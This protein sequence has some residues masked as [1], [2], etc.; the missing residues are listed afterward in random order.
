ME[1]AIRPFQSL[2]VAPPRRSQTSGNSYSAGPTTATVGGVAT[3]GNQI[4][5]TFASSAIAGSPVT[6]TYT[7]TGGDTLQTATLGIIAAINASAAL[8]AA[9]VAAVG[10]SGSPLEFT[11]NQPDALN[12]RAAV[13]GTV[14]G[15]LTLSLT[16]GVVA[17]SPGRGQVR[18]KTLNGSYSLSATVYNK[19]Y[20]RE[21]TFAQ[22]IGVNLPPFVIP[23]L[24]LP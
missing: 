22:S 14:T 6:V 4:A 19:K 15:T 5:F 24:T 10:V 20:P 23:P 21:V 12:P 11:I 8:A 18:M 17:I 3:V 16:S 2:A 1:G 13:T 9:G 7:L